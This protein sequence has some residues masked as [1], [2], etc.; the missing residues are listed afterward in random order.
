MSGLCGLTRD[1]G[2]DDSQHMYEA[3]ISLL[4][5][6]TPFKAIA[7]QDDKTVIAGQLSGLRPSSRNHPYFSTDL[8]AWFDGEIFDQTIGCPAE[9]I[10]KSYRE[11]HAFD[12]LDDLEGVFSCAVWDAAER[13]VHLAAD[14]LGLQFLYWSENGGRFCWASELKAFLGA[15]WISRELCAETVQAFLERGHFAGTGTWFRDVNLIQPAGVVTYDL[16]TRSVTVG[17]RDGFAALFGRGARKGE[18]EFRHDV[19]QEFERAVARRCL[20]GERIAVGL[21]G[22]LDSRA[23]L[24]A[25]PSATEGLCAYTFGKNGSADLRIA[26]AASRI[27]GVPHRVATIDESNWLPARVAAV[28]RSDGMLDLMH[29]HGVEALP[30]A[31]ALCDAELNGYLG[32]ALLGASYG[33][34]AAGIMRR[35]TD[36]GRRL[37]RS[38]LLVCK[39]FFDVRMPFVDSALLTAVFSLPPHDRAHSRF[40]IRMLLDRYPEYFQDLPWQKAGMPISRPFPLLRCGIIAGRIL[41]RFEGCPLPI[42]K[43][44]GSYTE[45]AAWIRSDPAQDI[46]V[47]LLA[48][49]GSVLKKYVNPALIARH[50]EAH[51]AHKDRSVILCRYLTLELWL[52]QMNDPRYRS[53]EGFCT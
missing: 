31:A 10:A 36:R 26:A 32:D 18:S 22:G 5:H 13:K 29:L 12:F 1:H 16:P 28:W 41:N 51:R 15:P 33:T 11:R 34:E 53:W 8:Y 19:G 21:S 43:G 7:A 27:R 23:I 44:M 25:V 9:F 30:Q 20:P 3:M 40:Y 48:D 47:R 38:A 24:A 52:R 39:P 2:G 50:L 6:G 49:R 37:V 46:F 17:S 42:S 14:R 35:F 45:Y 4:R